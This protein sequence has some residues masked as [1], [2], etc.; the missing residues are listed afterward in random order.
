MNVLFVSRS[1][2]GKPH[3]FIEEQG[4]ALEK[5][6]G[7]KIEH[8]LIRSGGARGY[9]K[10]AKELLKYTAEHHFDVIHAHYGLSALV[11]VINKLI[12]Q[13]K[14]KVVVTFHGS[15]IN[16]LSERPFSLLAS[17]FASHNIVVS[18]KML[19]FFSS[20]CS[21][22]PC[23]IDTGVAL[24]YREVTRKAY[25]WGENDFVV[26]FSSNFSRKVKD[27][28]FAFKVIEAVSGLIPKAVHFIELKGYTRSQVTSLMQAADALLMCSISEGSPQVIKEAILNALPIVSN[29][30]G[31]VKAI[32]TGVDNCFILPKEVQAYAACLQAIAERQPRI[33]H[34]EPVL[35]RYDND[36][37]SKLIYNIY[38]SAV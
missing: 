19:R 35:S 3:A 6:F 28:E 29:D 36:Q 20:N 13:K 22:I 5:N 18:E 16:K 9:L 26:L 34:R 38:S 12:A 33:L 15:D 30:V 27:P 23:G 21:F 37:I 24:N 11:A 4:A 25:T 17:R 14:L 10:S 1:K 7:I 31:D 8:F 32:C 2:T